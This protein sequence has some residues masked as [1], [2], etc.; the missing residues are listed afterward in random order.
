MNKTFFK[1]KILRRLLIIICFLHCIILTQAQTQVT[2]PMTS[3]PAAG[4]YYGISSITLSPNFNFTATAGNSFHAYILSP[5]C[6]PLANNFSQD[7]NYIVTSTPRVPMGNTF[8]TVGK[9]S[10]DLM[11]TVQY[12]DGLGRPLQTVQVKGSTINRDVVQPIA[13][14]Q[15]GREAVKY[16]C[17][18]G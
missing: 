7:Q 1:N 14:D 2:A 9:T 10:C 3:T 18:Y 12:F 15:F 4:E 6:S 16:H 17:A 11:Q 8:N 13:Y 5:D